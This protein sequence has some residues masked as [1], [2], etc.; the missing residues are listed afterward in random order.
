M[1]ENDQVNLEWNQSE[2]EVEQALSGGFK[3]AKDADEGTYLFK[4]IGVKARTNRDGDHIG[5]TNDDIPIYD[6]QFEIVSEGPWKGYIADMMVFSQPDPDHHAYGQKWAQFHNYSRQK[7]SRIVKILNLPPIQTLD[8]L[9]GSV[10][11]AEWK[12]SKD[13]NYKEFGYMQVPPPPIHE[14]H[15]PQAPEHVGTQGSPQKPVA[16]IPNNWG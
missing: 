15:E 1:D 7:V 3:N 8:E 16:A 12:C 9:K 4:M 11:Q 2:D 6:M 14:G 5:T 10:I 13:P